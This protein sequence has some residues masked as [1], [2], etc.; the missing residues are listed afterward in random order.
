MTLVN[1]GFFFIKDENEYETLKT[2]AAIGARGRTLRG[3]MDVNWRSYEIPDD[4]CKLKNICSFARGSLL[5]K[6]KPKSD[7]IIAILREGVAMCGSY[8]AVF[9][10]LAYTLGFTESRSVACRHPTWTLEKPTGHACCE[11]KVNG[12]WVMF[13]VLYDSCF[14]DGHCMS[15]YDIHLNPAVILQQNRVGRPIADW[16]FLKE[17]WQNDF[18]ITTNEGVLWFKENTVEDLYP[19]GCY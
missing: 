19:D 10:A 5:F 14:S 11:V 2:I 13:D 9:C 16:T 17:C 7:N 3:E 15:A 12:E 18:C 4:M 6:Q 8:C 1:K